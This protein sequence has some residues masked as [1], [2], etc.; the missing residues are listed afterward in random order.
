MSEDVKMIPIS[1]IRIVNPRHLD[2]KKFQVLVE[3]IGGLGLKKPVQVTCKAQE[4]A[5]GEHDYDL[6]CGQTRIEAYIAL[7]HTEIPAIINPP[8]EVKAV[9]RRLDGPSL[10]DLIEHE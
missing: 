1:R 2:K 5:S 6:V 9:E 7:G 3:S 8:H 10:P 4:D